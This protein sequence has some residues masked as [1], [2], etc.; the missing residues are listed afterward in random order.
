MAVANGGAVMTPGRPAVVADGVE[1][2]AEAF[3]DP[4]DPA[5]LLI[6]GASCSMDWWAEGLCARLA[7]GSRLVIRYDHRDTGRSTHYGVG[8]P[9]YDLADLAA[10]A[11]RVLDR[12]G[13]AAAH[14]VGISLGGMIAQR[15]ALEHPERVGSLTLM[16]TSPAGPG[17]P[18]NPDLPP[19]SAE[20]MARFAQPGPPVDWDDPAAAIE[21]ILAIQRSFAGSC[22]LDEAW[23][24]ALAG[25]VFDRTA[26]MAASMTNHGLIDHGEPI[27]SRLAEVVAPTTVIHGTEDPLFP[28]GHAEALAREIPGARL[29]PLPGVGHQMPP[30]AHWDVVVAAIRSLAI[31]SVRAAA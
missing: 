9:S 6:A 12:F 20:L 10:D 25:R 8:A 28:F 27:R 21:G 14:V 23:V 4:G 22:A 30:A 13:V 11:L 24:R 31:G 5:I 2:C 26:S 16:S 19:M 29:V 3:G 18:R 17:G 15:L 7:A 1:L